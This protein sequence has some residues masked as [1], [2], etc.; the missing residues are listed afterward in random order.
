MNLFFVKVDAIAIG[1]MRRR[2]QSA[3]KVAAAIPAKQRLA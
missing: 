1:K 2:S 3:H